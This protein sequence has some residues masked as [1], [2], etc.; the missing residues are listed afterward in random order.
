M[1]RFRSKHIK[2]VNRYAIRNKRRTR[3]E[4]KLKELYVYNTH[5][6]KFLIQVPNKYGV[7]L[8]VITEMKK[9]VN[10]QCKLQK[11]VYA[12]RSFTF[13]YESIDDIGDNSTIFFVLKMSN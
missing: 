8:D 7:A 2:N 1:G 11:F 12:G 9:K 4:T 10:N 6:V 3:S 13:L 5:G